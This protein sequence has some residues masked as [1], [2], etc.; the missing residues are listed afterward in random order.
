MSGLCPACLLGQALADDTTSETSG[1]LLA[2]LHLDAIVRESDEH[3]VFLAHDPA[4]PADWLTVSFSKRRVDSA[5][6]DAVT[7]RTQAL[8]AVRHPGVVPIHD[9]GIADTGHAYVIA[10][11]LAGRPLHERVRDLSATTRAQAFASAADALDAFHRRHIAHGHIHAAS[12]IVPRGSGERLDA[13]LTDAAPLPAGNASPAADVEALRDLWTQMARI[14]PGEPGAGGDL[15]ACR[16]AADLA[17]T[18]RRLFV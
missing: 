10:A 17:S 4:T 2:A 15:S 11:F 13:I 8:C 6:V 1:A 16:T 14:A 5:E 12:V 7:R 3:R 9:A 18:L